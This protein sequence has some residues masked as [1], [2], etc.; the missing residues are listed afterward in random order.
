MLRWPCWRW[1]LFHIGLRQALD[2]RGLLPDCVGHGSALLADG[3]G[4]IQQG[5]GTVQGDRQVAGPDGHDPQAELAALHKAIAAKPSGILISV[6]DVT[7]AAAGDRRGHQRR[8]SGHHHGLG[9]AGSR[10]LYFIG[11]NNL[12]AGRLGGSA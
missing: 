6:A 9:C 3:G 10:R 8:H 12:E 2:Q 7:G 5:R 11:T 1:Q 4:G